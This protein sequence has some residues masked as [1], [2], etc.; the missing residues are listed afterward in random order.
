[1]GTLFLVGEVFLCWLQ[2]VSLYY[3]W[4]DGCLWSNVSVWSSA[5]YAFL[6]CSTWKYENFSLQYNY[7]VQLKLP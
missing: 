4:F 2:C 3:C 7:V 6:Y 5:W 1:M